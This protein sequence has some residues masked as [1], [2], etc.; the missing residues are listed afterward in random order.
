[1]TH[2]SRVR[3]DCARRN[4]NMKEPWCRLWSDRQPL[5]YRA[6]Q[7]PHQAPTAV[8][9]TRRDAFDERLDAVWP[10]W[11]YTLWAL[12][13][14]TWH[15]R[16]VANIARAHEMCSI[17]RRAL[18]CS[19]S[20]EW[21]HDCSLGFAAYGN[22]M[23]YLT[24]I[25][26]YPVECDVAAVAACCTVG[27][28]RMCCPDRVYRSLVSWTSRCRPVY[29]TS[30]LCL[31][32]DCCSA[33][34]FGMDVFAAAV[35]VA[36]LAIHRPAPR[37]V[38]W[39]SMWHVWWSIGPALID[40]THG[41]CVVAAIKAFVDISYCYS[42]L[43][44]H[45]ISLPC[46]TYLVM[47][48]QL[49]H[50]NWCRPRC[51][52]LLSL[53]CHR[54]MPCCAWPLS[55]RLGWPLH[56]SAVASAVDA[57]AAAAADDVAVQLNRGLDALVSC[58]VV[59]D[60][61]IS[62]NHYAYMRRV[63][64]ASPPSHRTVP[65]MEWRTSNPI[66]ISYRCWSIAIVTVLYIQIMCLF[67]GLTSLP[68]LT[69]PLSETSMYVPS[70]DDAAARVWCVDDGASSDELRSCLCECRLEMFLTRGLDDRLSIGDDGWL[71]DSDCYLLYSNHNT[72]VHKWKRQK[73][74]GKEKKKHNRN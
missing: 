5:G 30:A 70:W 60:A 16:W 41:V 48:R 53:R 11:A 13:T 15:R 35:A 63:A 72:S 9:P 2:D 59:A 46:S 21:R 69:L 73:K 40:Y 28:W 17:E 42:A 51:G 33:A 18:L 38:G 71:A 10:T 64:V 7:P 8:W 36:A 47:F 19:V 26:E 20:S 37:S 23:W 50:P 1:M 67:N 32:P 4:W 66:C 43:Q 27:R 58:S 22:D 44:R 56:T 12:H 55:N 61:M 29:S 34:A 52:P 54:P 74:M 57:A 6:S 39:R 62:H 31:W 49:T 65:A 24:V 25:A 14:N 68:I 3:S 45:R